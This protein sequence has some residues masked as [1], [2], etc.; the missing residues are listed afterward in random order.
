MGARDTIDW[1]EKAYAD[2]DD[3]LTWLS[4][5]AL[6]DECRADPRFHALMRRMGYASL[7]SLRHPVRN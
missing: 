5:D 3:M 2:R 1:L 6:F 7:E 4:V